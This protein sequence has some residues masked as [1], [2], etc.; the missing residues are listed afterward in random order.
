[1]RLARRRGPLVAAILLLLWLAGG[2]DVVRRVG[3]TLLGLDGLPAGLELQGQLYYTQG[4]DGLWRHDLQRGVS[5]RWWLPE[6]GSLVSG[7]AAAPDGS[8]LALAWAP[9]G[10][11]GFQPGTTDLWLTDLPAVEPRPLL[12]REDVFE[13][14]RDPFW[15]PD[16]EWLLVTH[17]RATR[18]AGGEVRNIHLTVERVAPDGR[19]ATLLEDAEQAALSPDGAQLAYLRVDPESWAQ[20]LMHARAAGSEA[21]ELVAAATF[22]ALASPRFTPD[23]EAVVFSA[24]GPR[25]EAEAAVVNGAGVV[26]AHGAPWHIWQVSLADGELSRLTEQTLDGPALAWAPDGGDALAVLAAEGLYLRARGRLWR[27][28]AV[29][30][31][32]GLSWAAGG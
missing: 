6:A 24:S 18:D 21:R 15:S 29:S 31:E 26:R 13:A 17:Q 8:R 3:L 1:M 7:V 5:E 23:G 27:V 14:W 28:A 22:L 30:A 4:F 12:V 10:A 2:Q 25:R 11:D 19:R 16:G 9:P 32:G 20:S